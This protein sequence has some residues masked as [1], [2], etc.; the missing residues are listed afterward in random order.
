M[1]RGRERRAERVG[2]NVRRTRVQ[3]AVG[4]HRD[5]ERTVAEIRLDRLRGDVCRNEQR[6][7]GVA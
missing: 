6:R 3:V 7:T 4:I 2:H 1:G 5:L